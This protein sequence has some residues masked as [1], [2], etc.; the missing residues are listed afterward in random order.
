MKISIILASILGLAPL[1]TAPVS[2]VGSSGCSTEK[3]GTAEVVSCT[4]IGYCGSGAKTCFAFEIG[5]AQDL[6]DLL[7]VRVTEGCEDG[8]FPVAQG[9]HGL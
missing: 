7:A 8:D 6:D 9:H 2:A 4:S 1:Q 5:S 3:Y